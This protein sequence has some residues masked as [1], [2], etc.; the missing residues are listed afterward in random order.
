MCR[1]S[2]DVL[3]ISDMCDAVTQSGLVKSSEARPTAE[4][5]A[6]FSNPPATFSLMLR[7][8]DNV[9]VGLQVK[10]WALTVYLKSVHFDAF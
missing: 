7:L 3:Y 2:Y 1:A 10:G 8:A 9:P 4:A 5:A 6:G